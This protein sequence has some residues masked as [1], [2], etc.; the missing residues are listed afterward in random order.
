MSSLCWGISIFFLWFWDL[1]FVY[2]ERG[3]YLGVFI[4]VRD[5]LWTFYKIHNSGHRWNNHRSESMYRK[6]LIEYSQYHEKKT[7]YHKSD[8]LFVLYWMFTG[9]TIY[10]HV[11]VYNSKFTIQTVHGNCAILCDKSNSM[12]KQR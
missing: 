3:V 2:K 9:H 8:N 4:Q 6:K 12:V 7:Q 11:H 1:R 5:G 10:P